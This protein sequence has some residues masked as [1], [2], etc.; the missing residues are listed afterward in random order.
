MRAVIQRVSE[1]DVSVE[2]ETTGAIGSGLVVLVGV[3][4]GDSER[5]AA[6]L[7]TKIV[8]LRIFADDDRKMNR[9]IVDAGGSVLL[10]SQFT[11]LADVSK[12]RRPAFTAAAPPEVAEPL[13]ATLAASIEA[14]G[15]VVEH[16]RFGAMMDVSLTNDGPVTI[17][18]DVVNGKV[19]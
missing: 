4:T 15:V 13:L 11:L 5:D 2:G 16:G 18:M 7:A 17:V 14:E 12:G 10:I 6:V 9:S 3:A 8:G 1:A 19:E